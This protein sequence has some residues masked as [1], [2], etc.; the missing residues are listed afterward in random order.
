MLHIIILLFVQDFERGKIADIVERFQLATLGISYPFRRENLL[1]AGM[2]IE[3]RRHR[4]RS[5]RLYDWDAYRFRNATTNEYFTVCVG[6]YKGAYESETILHILKGSAYPDN[7]FED[8][9]A[10][11]YRPW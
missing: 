10:E 9:L 2:K 11:Q 7:S 6:H 5:R 8:F 3:G 4:S 1:V